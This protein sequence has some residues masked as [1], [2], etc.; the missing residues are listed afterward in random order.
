M[1]KTP[2]TKPTDSLMRKHKKLKKPLRPS[3]TM[4][5]KIKILTVTVEQKYYIPM[6]DDKRSKI[7][8]W[9]VEQ[10]IED[11]FKTHSL[12]SS[13]ATRDAHIIET[14]QKLIKVEGDICEQ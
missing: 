8:G 3:K 9:T 7:N 6:Y 4:E 11:W 1:D 10:V 13:H 2:R 5:E 14:S 12:G